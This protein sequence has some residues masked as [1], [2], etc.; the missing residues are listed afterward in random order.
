MHRP[1]PFSLRVTCFMARSTFAVQA[2]DDDGRQKAVSQKFRC[3]FR[4]LP[5]QK[6]RT[7]SVITNG[8]IYI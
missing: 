6:D 7:V 5:I 8:N 1:P 2:D 3:R 4:L